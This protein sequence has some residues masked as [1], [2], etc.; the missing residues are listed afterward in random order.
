SKVLLPK[1]LTPEQE[2]LVY[3]LDSQAKLEAE[4]IEITLGDVTLPLEHI[5]RN[6]LPPRWKTFRQIVNLSQTTEDWENVLRMLEGFENA[7][8][9]VKPWVQAMVVRKMNLAGMHHLLL[10]AI[11]RPRATGI[12]L[13]NREVLVQLLRAVHDKASMADW[14]QDDTAK[15]LR[16]AQQAVE[17]MEDE[18]HCGGQMRGEMTS[19][20]DWRGEPVVVALPTEMAAVLADRYGVHGDEVAKL[21]NRLVNAMKQRDY[22]TH[23]DTMAQRAATTPPDFPNG[24]HQELFVK[25]Y[26]SQL[27]QLTITW[28]ALKTSRKVLGADMPMAQEAQQYEARNEEVLMQGLDA[29]ER[30]SVMKDGKPFVSTFIEYVKNNVKKCR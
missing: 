15:A 14:A 6:A 2:K 1:H 8:I 3:K 22:M 26:G 9:A 25:D 7:R 24:S 4:P 13:S 19:G 18:E 12:R 28:N 23:L 21:A 29:L 17:L 10:K 27:L 11:Q 30:L 16:L 20:D 5:D